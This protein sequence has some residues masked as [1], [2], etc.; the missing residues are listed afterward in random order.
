VRVEGTVVDV[1]GKPLANAPLG[2]T[3]VESGGAFFGSGAP[4][5]GD[6]TFVFPSLTP[7]E[8]V[9]RTLPMPQQKDVAVMKLTVGT[10]DIRDLRL[11]AM[12]PATISGRI[13]VDPA[14]AQMLPNPL[15]LVAQSSDSMIGG[16]TPTRVAD[17]LTF[18]LQATVGRNHINPFSLPA[19]WMVRAV[20]VNS[21]DVTDEGIE[22]KQSEA[23]TG[24]DI[25]LTN[26][27]ATIS[28]AVTTADGAA[29]KD[30]TVIVFAA[31][32]RRWTPNSRYQR[33]GRPDQDGRFKV[34]GLPPADYDVV[35]VD[36][37]DSGQWTDPEFLQRI[38]GKANAVTVTEG[39]TRTVDLKLA[40]G[41]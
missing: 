31:D 22:V 23:I 2:I 34:T 36:R 16:F 25:E 10:E 12:P 41:S 38:S 7:G 1:N 5:R 21:I 9:L 26:K 8:Y 14:Q 37:I 30:Y 28:G 4:V 27:S 33:I 29:A 40:T 13:V 15:M 3:R 18:E 11:V 39:E 20:R 35:A 17:D 32:S 24:V 6:G 19:G